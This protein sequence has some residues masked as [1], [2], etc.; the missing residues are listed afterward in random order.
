MAVKPTAESKQGLPARLQDNG[1][2]PPVDL[3][4]ENARL[5]KELASAKFALKAS[6][7]ESCLDELQR[8]L[9]KHKCHLTALTDGRFQVILRE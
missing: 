4:A 2:L 8:V 9:D 3:V 7:E 1:D 5:T 6:K